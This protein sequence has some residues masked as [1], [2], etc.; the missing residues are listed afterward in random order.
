MN[1]LNSFLDSLSLAKLYGVWP[2]LSL[3]IIKSKRVMKAKNAQSNKYTQV[4]FFYQNKHWLFA[5]H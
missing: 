5:V 2:N 3:P 4:F 1:F